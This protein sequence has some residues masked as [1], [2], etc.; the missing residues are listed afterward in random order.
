LG[1][2]RSVSIEE[3]FTMACR[4]L[5]VSATATQDKR[6]LRPNASEVLVLQSDP[7]RALKLLGWRPTVT[8][9]EGLERTASWLQE[10]RSC[11]RPDFLYA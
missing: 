1:T 4:V 7:S 8:L 10:N 2:G 5:G 3:L 11:Y 9:E 6:R